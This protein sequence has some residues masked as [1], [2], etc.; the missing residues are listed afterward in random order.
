[1]VYKVSKGGVR[2]GN[3]LRC[4][5]SVR[6]R[7]YSS[8]A[9]IL[10]RSNIHPVDVPEFLESATED[11]LVTSA[12]GSTGVLLSL[13]KK[14]RWTLPATVSHLIKSGHFNEGK[15]LV[16]LLERHK[17][18]KKAN[19]VSFVCNQSRVRNVEPKKKGYFSF[20]LEN[21][22]SENS[23]RRW[24]REK[25]AVMKKLKT[26]EV[27]ITK[28]KNNKP[29]KTLEVYTVMGSTRDGL[30]SKNP[31]YRVEVF[32]PC[33]QSCSLV[34]NPKYTNIP[35]ENGDDE[36][37]E[38][39]VNTKLVKHKKRF[40]KRFT[41]HDLK[42]YQDEIDL[43][44]FW[45][46]DFEESD[47]LSDTDIHVSCQEGD[48]SPIMYNQQTEENTQEYD[49]EE[50]VDLTENLLAC[51]IS[52]AEK[53][54]S[55]CGKEAPPQHQKDSSR[56]CKDSSSDEEKSHIVYIDYIPPVPMESESITP[57]LKKRKSRKQRRLKRKLAS[58]SA[59]ASKLETSKPETSKPATGL[60]LHSGRVIMKSTNTT[61]EV[62][63][64]KYGFCYSEADSEPR[65]FIINVTDDVYNLM[66]THRYLEQNAMYTSYLVFVHDGV[67]DE[68]LDT[69]KVIFNSNIC[70]DTE[71]VA[72][73][74]PFQETSIETIMNHVV[75]ALLDMKEENLLSTNYPPSQETT[76]TPVLKFV[77]DLMRVR[78]ETFRT[79]DEISRV[80]QTGAMQENVN[81]SS[82]FRN[83][84][85]DLDFDVFCDICY[86]NVN[87]SQAG[88][89]FGTRLTRCGHVFCDE[90]WRAHFRAKINNGALKMVCPGYDCDETVGPVTLLSLLH[91]SEVTKLFQRKCE[92]EMEATRN[93]LW[94]PN[95]NCVRIVKLGSETSVIDA[96]FDV[97]CECGQEFCCLCLSQPHWPA[98]CIQ[99]QE[100]RQ[101][102]TDP[103]QNHTDDSSPIEDA[104]APLHPSSPKKAEVMEIEG[105]LC[106]KCS[107]FID[108]NGGCMHM[109]C[110]C[111]H[112]F[113]WLCLKDWYNHGVC[114]PDPSVV[115][116]HTQ[117]VKVNHIAIPQIRLNDTTTT[118][119][120]KP[121]RSRQRTSV[122]QKARHER[123]EAKHCKYHAQIGKMVKELA[124]FA[125]KDLLFKREV[126][127]LCGKEVK[128]TDESGLT[129]AMF[130]SHVTKFLRSCVGVKRALHHVAEFTFVL[131]QD[132]PDSVDR[133]RILKLANDIS[134]YC[135]F[136]RSILDLGIKQDLRVALRRLAN[137]QAWSKRTLTVLLGSVKQ[138]K[139]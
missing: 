65:R 26:P 130:T 31:E 60:D 121:I 4:L 62:L 94:C 36:M 55:L 132:I 7:R 34:Y 38:T 63:R 135:S 100:Y 89:V 101:K 13:N 116:E 83:M 43:E 5:R 3:T 30:A 120:P 104:P 124:R 11:Q 137:I 20:N 128:A 74:I 138:I 8:Q 71:P 48:D 97:T 115:F 53:A 9:C 85:R 113:C 87:S 119:T 127:S 84:I 93:S 14:A 67:Y 134:G 45:S 23:H 6:T 108:K 54:R 75:S 102:L 131:V 47:S 139:Y 114:L 112:Q 35:V 111:G 21:T 86:E 2:S 19:C 70:T 52:Q 15:T 95:P 25:A 117:K 59:E 17:L 106:P 98:T 80:S 129:Y 18:K 56:Y 107:K 109:S 27:K 39:K 29:V 91:V 32:R 42:M 46:D 51:L 123:L 136:I 1:M 90:C 68:G 125:Q 50:P 61:P 37:K 110:R 44:G 40:R 79:F 69:F 57:K 133:K 118:N 24:R 88:S 122:Y 72:K 12:L 33:P 78:V 96:S 105:R 58:E 16:S 82:S 22:D 77:N 41:S 76:V 73:S 99:A 103:S 81:I 92:G 66:C 10:S 49:S 126:L 64:A 28:A